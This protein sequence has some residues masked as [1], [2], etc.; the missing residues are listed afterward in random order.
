[1]GISRFST[2]STLGGLIL[3]V[4]ACALFKP[5]EDARLQNGV[6]D[7]VASGG[8]V[9]HISLGGVNDGDGFAARRA[10]VGL[11]QDRVLAAMEGDG[12]KLIHRYE[13][14]AAL[15]GVLSES[16]L[17]ALMARSELRRVSLDL[18]GSGALDDSV[19]QISANQWAAVGETGAGSIVAVLDSGVVDHPDLSDDL[20]HESCILGARVAAGG[21]PCPDGSAQ[22]LDTAGSALDGHGHGTNVA[23]IVTSGGSVTPAGVAPG[24]QLIAV[25]IF[26]D[27]NNFSATDAV[28]A[29]DYLLTQKALGALDMRVINISGGALPPV[30]ECNLGIGADMGD[31][32]AALEAFGVLTVA[33]AGNDSQTTRLAFPACVDGVFAV[34]AVDDDNDPLAQS[35]VAPKLDVL[36]PGRDITSAGITATQISTLTGSSQAA[37]HV[38]GCAAL[39]ISDDPTLTVAELKTIL[40]LTSTFIDIPGTGLTFPRLFCGLPPTI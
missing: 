24:A 30:G 28:M 4:G 26:D 11:A 3:A 6:G 5:V 31:L 12:F 9:V 38:A 33:A 1:M 37:P 17:D 19:S 25:K 34:G 14:V 15:T 27:D 40:T 13:N 2:L 23:G 7:A 21:L 39:R 8:A 36:A 35:N 20:I 10:S 18:K 29:L 22:T 16:G 32:V